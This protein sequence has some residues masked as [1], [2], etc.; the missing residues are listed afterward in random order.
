[1]GGLL[2]R[3]G[4]SMNELAL[5]DQEC[6]GPTPD[7]W[8]VG[9]GVKKHE[10]MRAPPRGGGCAIVDRRS[11][12]N[13]RLDSRLTGDGAPVVCPQHLVHERCDKVSPLTE[14]SGGRIILTDGNRLFDRTTEELRLGAR[15]GPI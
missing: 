9:G 2:W 11:P 1:M 13:P 6:E 8:P 5:S 10:C 4:G 7:I 12:V 14:L 15:S 3:K